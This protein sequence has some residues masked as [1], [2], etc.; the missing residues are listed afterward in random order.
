MH[1]GHFQLVVLS[2]FKNQPLASRPRV[3]G[4][5]CKTTLWEHTIRTTLLQK[6]LSLQCAPMW[7]P[8]DVCETSMNV[9]CNQWNPLVQKRI[10]WKLHCRRRGMSYP[11][12]DLWWVHSLLRPDVA[13]RSSV[14]AS[15]CL[16][17]FR[18]IAPVLQL[19]RQYFPIENVIDGY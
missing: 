16:H 19:S 5:Q 3:H 6:Y 17:C 8:R 14:F 15:N 11:L 10:D 1:P 4:R 7:I 9:V 13:N 18:W 2:Q 12:T